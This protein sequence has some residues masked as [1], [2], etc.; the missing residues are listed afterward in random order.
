[1]FWR[2]VVA[3]QAEA[4]ETG[5]ADYQNNHMSM[6]FQEGLSFSGYERDYLG[7]NVGGTELID[8]SGVSGLDSIG[9]GRGAALADFDNDGDLDIFLVS[10]QHN[11][12]ELFRN[13]VGSDHGFVRV[14]LEGTESGRDGF[15]AI[16]R[17]GTANGVVTK[18]KS[19]GSGFL[20]QNDPRLLIGLGEAM[21]ADWIEVSWPSGLVQRVEGLDGATGIPAGTSLLIREG[22]AA[23]RVVEQTF[24]LADPLS[25]EERTFA[26]LTFGRGDVFPD[27][28]LLDR[29]V[30][31]DGDDL[32]GAVATSVHQLLRP[33]RRTLLNIWATWC[34]PCRREM[35]ELEQLSGPLAAAGV[36]LIG[37]SIDTDTVARVVPFLNDMG[38]T[39]AVHVSNDERIP[40]LYE[41]GAIAVPLSVLLDD[42]GRVL[43]V[44][45]GWSVETAEQF[46]ELTE[47]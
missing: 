7:M 12:H 10:F 31:P 20:A 27:L 13:N 25:S 11:A 15:G 29:D 28:A 39:Y 47:R 8:V 43:Q 40:G 35:P 33:G 4:E 6:I 46:H 45:G 2:H 38:T 30:V 9:D 21:Q 19:A 23:T 3:A 34:V 22:G 41:G 42:Q 24:A 16:V 26:G 44:I 17:A 36:D 18:L 5:N 14:T 1:V 37:I 32:P